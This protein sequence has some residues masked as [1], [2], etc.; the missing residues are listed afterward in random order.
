MALIKHVFDVAAFRAM[1]PA[2]ADPLKFP[3]VMLQGYW[4]M[5]C[6][7]INDYDNV[8][9][10]GDNLQLA[11]NLMSAHLAKS[12]AMIDAG[13]LVV[14]VAGAAEGTVSISTV[15][16]PAKSGYQWWLCT[17]PY[18]VQ[19]WALLSSIAVGGYYIGGNQELSSFRRG[20]GW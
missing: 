8:A 19:L 17:T 1:F 12:Y 13:D 14:V 16:P 9:I 10:D 6:N 7:Y 20:G 5:A 11:L 2:F 15:P 3:D 4:T 18:G